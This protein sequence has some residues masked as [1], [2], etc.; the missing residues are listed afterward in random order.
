[1]VVII[2]NNIGLVFFSFLRKKIYSNFNFFF[3]TVLTGTYERSCFGSSIEALVYITLPVREIPVGRL[4]E[5][6]GLR[7]EFHLPLVVSLGSDSQLSLS[8]GEQQ[9]RFLQ[10]GALPDPQGDLVPGGPPVQARS[11]AASPVRAAGPHLRNT[12]H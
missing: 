11:E 6:V 1:M 5:L 12:A 8:T 4:M 2:L 10:P 9:G 7:A 3:F